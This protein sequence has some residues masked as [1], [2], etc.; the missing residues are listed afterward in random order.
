MKIADLRNYSLSDKP[1]AWLIREA[2]QND[3]INPD[4]EIQLTG[5][6]SVRCLQRDSAARTNI[7]QYRAWLCESLA[8]ALIHEDATIVLRAT[9]Q[10]W[11]YAGRLRGM[12][13]EIGSHYSDELY[14][15]R[16]RLEDVL[17]KIT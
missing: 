10:A 3:W 5:V 11:E 1:G 16:N 14:A 2:G 6:F 4:Y 7:E 8:T 9:L 17:R 13:Y 12:G 15:A